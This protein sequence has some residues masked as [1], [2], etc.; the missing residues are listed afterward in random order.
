M[1][2]F[3]KSLYLSIFANKI[4]NFAYIFSGSAVPFLPKRSKTLISIIG[5]VVGRGRGIK[6]VDLK[7]KVHPF[8]GKGY[9]HFKE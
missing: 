6:I 8:R 2:F 5:E 7:G 4:P 3:K 9:E 1:A